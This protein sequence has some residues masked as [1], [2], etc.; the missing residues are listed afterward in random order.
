LEILSILYSLREKIEYHLKKSKIK[1][2]KCF[3]KI[4]KLLRHISTL[5]AFEVTCEHHFN[6]FD[7]LSKMIQSAAGTAA[8]YP[9]CKSSMDNLNLFCESWENQVNDL[10]VLV[11]ELQELINGVKSNKSV[12]F[13]LPRP[14]VLNIF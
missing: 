14:G 2:N 4:C 6:V 3:F 1:F 7:Y 8:L 10:S 5:D 13:S 12:Y 11:K 9:Q